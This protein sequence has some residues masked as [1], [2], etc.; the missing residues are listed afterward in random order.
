[1]QIFQDLSAAMTLS[2]EYIKHVE[3]IPDPESYGFTQAKAAVLE[4]MS[5]PLQIIQSFPTEFIFGNYSARRDM[6]M[7]A[8]LSDRPITGFWSETLFPAIKDIVGYGADQLQ[9]SSF[10]SD[11]VDAAVDAAAVAMGVL[12]PEFLPLIL[13][14]DPLVKKGASGLANGT[15]ERIKEWAIKGAPDFDLNNLPN[16]QFFD[17][18]MGQLCIESKPV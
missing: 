17:K 11:M 14:A 1:M 10:A 3:G 8:L 5:S 12:A 9:S 6:I 7:T 2:V 16:V 4:N 13:A 15:L 18:N